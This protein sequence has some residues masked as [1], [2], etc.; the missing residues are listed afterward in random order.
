MTH[1]ELVGRAAKWLKHQKRSEWR[2]PI[3]LTEYRCFANEQPD[4][5]GLAHQHTVLIECK[6]S[7]QD[8]HND[9]KKQH[10]EQAFHLGTYRFYFCETGLITL[11]QLPVNWGLLYLQPNNN[12]SVVHHPIPQSHSITRIEEYQVLYSLVRRLTSLDGHDKTLNT[13]R[14]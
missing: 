13:L 5:F 6:T 9:A 7:I 12:V 1:D 14:S 8:F 2:C 11:F 3:I 10:R 4:V